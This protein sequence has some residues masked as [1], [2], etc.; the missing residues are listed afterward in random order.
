MFPKLNFFCGQK[1][2]SICGRKWS[3]LFPRPKRSFPFRF[4]PLARIRPRFVTTF[5]HSVCPLVAQFHWPGNVKLMQQVVAAVVHYEAQLPLL[6]RT[7]VRQSLSQSRSIIQ[8][9]LSTS[10]CSAAMWCSVVTYTRQ[11]YDWTPAVMLPVV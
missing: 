5:G 10:R 4:R 8:L 6:I 1:T 3:Q 11:P 2:A 9:L 7:C